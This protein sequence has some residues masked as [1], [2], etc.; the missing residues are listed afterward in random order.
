MTTKSTS[1]E[2][3]E[4]AP[5]AK[6]VKYV[7]RRAPRVTTRFAVDDAPLFHAAR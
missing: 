3:G 7:P 2:P 4:A 6:P 1:V 5:A